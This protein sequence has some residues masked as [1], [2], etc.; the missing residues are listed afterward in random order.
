MGHQN[1]RQRQ[2]YLI[3]RLDDDMHTVFSPCIHPT[4][5]NHTNNNT[6]FLPECE[7]I[8]R[9][10]VKRLA[11]LGNNLVKGMLDE[12]I[13]HILPE[14]T[15]YAVTC[16]VFARLYWFHFLPP[17]TPVLMSGLPVQVIGSLG[18]RSIHQSPLP[19]KNK[20][21]IFCIIHDGQ[22]RH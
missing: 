8:L 4:T 17:S 10:C 2:T 22:Q 18:F 20:E 1:A 5:R 3:S 9:K 11:V 16:S 19:P 7:F 12:L 14:Y 15:T 21:Y 6:S 13:G